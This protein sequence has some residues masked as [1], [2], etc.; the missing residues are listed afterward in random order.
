MFIEEVKPKM[1]G[2]WTVIESVMEGTEEAITDIILLT[3]KEKAPPG[4][5][6]VGRT[7]D[8]IIHV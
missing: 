3:K 8:G 7:N 4:Y 6:V 2:E 5:H 1:S